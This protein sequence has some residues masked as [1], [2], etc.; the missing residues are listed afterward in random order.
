MI[1]L[2]AAID[3]KFGIAK[4]GFQPW[5]IPIDEHYFLEQTARHGG[6]VLMGK[7]TF[8]VISHP[9]K[10][11]RNIVLS[12]QTGHIEGVEVSDDLHMT[13]ST[14]A[15]VWIIGGASVFEQTLPHADELYLTRIDADFGCDQFFPNFEDRFKL[16]KKGDGQEQNGFNF[17]FEI[18]KPI[19]K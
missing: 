16:V 8:E 10:N 12:R 1:R 4:H 3:R 19:T 6:V 5:N 2:I 7:R 11:R 17:R 13:L 9:L 18:W 14:L 15:D